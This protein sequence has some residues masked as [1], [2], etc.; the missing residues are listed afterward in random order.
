MAAP[1]TGLPLPHAY[2][3]VLLD[4][5]VDVQRGA[6]A[7]A[8]RN[9]TRGDP[10]LDAAGMLPAALLAE[11]MAQCTGVAVAGGDAGRGGMLVHIDRFRCRTHLAAGQAGRTL[12]VRMRITKIFGA[13]VKAR[14]VIWIDQRR[15]AAGELIVQLVSS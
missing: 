14:G 3:F 11:V 15:C 1:R 12:R 8:I 6:H 5:I 2:P 4:R 9:L 10:L 7:E 13:T